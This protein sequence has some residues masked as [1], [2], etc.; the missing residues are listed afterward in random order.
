MLITGAK[1]K[2]NGSEYDILRMNYGFYRKIDHKGRP[3]S[4]EGAFVYSLNREETILFFSK[5]YW[6]MCPLSGAVSRW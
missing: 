1:L 6:K 3:G 4:A 2:I 5:C